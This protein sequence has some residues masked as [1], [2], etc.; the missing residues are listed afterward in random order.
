MENHLAASATPV[1][2]VCG[3]LDHV[4]LDSVVR[5]RYKFPCEGFDD[6][7]G[8][9]TVGEEIVELGSD[10]QDACWRALGLDLGR[11]GCDE[12]FPVRRRDRGCCG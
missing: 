2:V 5:L 11:N 8:V 1:L 4:G 6:G 12:G 9:D 7:G 3:P 10:L